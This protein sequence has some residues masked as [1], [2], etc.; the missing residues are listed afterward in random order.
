MDYAFACHSQRGMYMHNRDNAVLYD[1]RLSE[2]SLDVKGLFCMKTKIKYPKLTT[3]AAMLLGASARANSLA[4]TSEQR[5]A[6]LRGEDCVLTSSQVACCTGMGY[7]IVQYDQVVLGVG[8]FFPHIGDAGV[9]R[10]LFP[11]YL[12]GG[13]SSK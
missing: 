5:E 13:E 9:L 8:L 12:Q 7:V 3:S 4:L 1:H 11:R 6:Y 10:S 2:L